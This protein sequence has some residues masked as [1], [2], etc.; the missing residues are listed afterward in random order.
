MDFMV[1]AEGEKLR[2]AKSADAKSNSEMLKRMR[3]Q[4]KVVA[5]CETFFRQMFGDK[6]IRI[7]FL[8]V[9][10]YENKYSVFE[11]VLAE[12]THFA[13]FDLL[14]ELLCQEV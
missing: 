6:T 10:E 9:E 4:R 8:G 12:E 3:K 11:R 1:I 5:D 13:C 7:D 14:L 2:V